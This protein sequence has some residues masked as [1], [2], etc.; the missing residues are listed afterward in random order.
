MLLISVLV[1]APRFSAVREAAGTPVLATVSWENAPR[2]P[3]YFFWEAVAAAAAE[4]LVGSNGIVVTMLSTPKA[5]EMAE[6]ASLI[7]AVVRVITA[8]LVPVPSAF[9]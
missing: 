7:F 3:A 8:P 1:A 6:L 2:A 9:L 5:L 4:A